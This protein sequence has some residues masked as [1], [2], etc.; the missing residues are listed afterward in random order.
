MK[1]SSEQKMADL[2][3]DRVTPGKP[4]FSYVGV[5]CFGPF[6]MKRSQWIV[7][8]YGV[9]FTCLSICVVHNQSG[10]YLGY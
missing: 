8:R 4:P 5:D 3:E 1:S 6:K 9:L 10:A 2:P 7:K